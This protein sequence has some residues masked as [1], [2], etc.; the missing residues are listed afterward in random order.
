MT[1]GRSRIFRPG[2]DSGRP[3]MRVQARQGA[4]SRGGSALSFYG[5]TALSVHGL[6]PSQSRRSSHCKV[7][8]V[9]WILLL[10]AMQAPAWSAENEALTLQVGETLVLAAPEVARVA[11]GD[12][13]VANAAAADR[14]EVLVFGRAAGSTSL[15][16][17]LE[18]GTRRAYAVRVEPAGMRRIRDE[19]AALLERIPNARSLIVGERIVIE[20]EDLS[21]SDQR[22]IAALAQRYPEVIDFTSRIGWDRMVLLDVQ[23]VELPRSTLREWGVRWD[24]TSQGG[25]AA[26]LAWDAAGSGVAARPGEA[27]IDAAFPAAS[28]AGYF[29]VNALLS[30]R[31]HALSQNGDA[32]M[33][34]QPQLLARSGAT[35]NFLAGGEVPYATVDANGN[36][37]TIFK[38]YGVSLKITPHVERNGNV[39]SRIEVEVSSVDP[40]I[41]APGGPA[42]SVRRAATEF[43]VRSG[44]TLVLGGF[45][46]REQ[47]TDLQR[48]PGLGDIP[49]LG[50]L[51]G[52]R[53]FQQ[54]ETELAIFV[55]PVLA[56]A[57][58]PDMA[59]R[60]ARGREALDAAF[61]EPP[62][63]N[64]PVRAID[65]RTPW[66]PYSGP[67][68]Q[69]RDEPARNS[70]DFTD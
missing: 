62:R 15:H 48:L 68:S 49:V 2:F 16:I 9:M 64:T 3:G 22:R 41:T 36:S 43:N 5:R 45:L 1:L 55:T 70:H 54:R 21:D 58:H 10:A 23:V 35:A 6:P 33:L 11:V 25:L 50:A 39:R 59:E 20:G 26:G 60:V 56:G 18:D 38:P 66:D 24:G 47:S 30:A 67:A 51:F 8:W 31:L 40:S 4:F 27:P 7:R 29:G 65:G 52:S 44:Q 32:V 69:W 28:A 61:P 53:R 14:R 34:A 57:D 63:M 13:R 19:L 37:T 17:W 46:S 42:L 12:S